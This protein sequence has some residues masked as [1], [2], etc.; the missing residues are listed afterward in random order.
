M[1]AY[2]PTVSFPPERGNSISF[3]KLGV[4]A[5]RLRMVND[6]MNIEYIQMSNEIWSYGVSNILLSTNEGLHE[7]FRDEA[8]NM[9]TLK[10][11]MV[12]NGDNKSRIFYLKVVIKC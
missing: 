5:K 9:E 6:T 1:H 4:A 3:Q 2:D 11:L 7:H 12:D 8:K 10:D